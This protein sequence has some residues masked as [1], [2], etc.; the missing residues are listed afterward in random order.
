[1]LGDSPKFARNMRRIHVLSFS[2]GF[3][4]SFDW[5]NACYFSSYYALF[6][7]KNKP[8]SQGTK[9]AHNYFTKLLIP[10]THPVSFTCHRSVHLI[11]K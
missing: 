4:F 8:C 1:M 3:G 11:T 10:N 5:V 9:E 2:L 6:L 7:I